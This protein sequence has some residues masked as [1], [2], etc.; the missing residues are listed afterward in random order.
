LLCLFLVEH[1]QVGRLLVRLIFILV[2]AGLFAVVLLG[3]P[4]LLLRP[5][6][7]GFD[8]VLVRII[9][10]L[11]L[12]GQE[13]FASSFT[14]LL[15]LFPLRL[16][17]AV[18]LVDSLAPHDVLLARVNGH[19]EPLEQLAH[20]TMVAVDFILSKGRDD[21][22]NVVDRLISFEIICFLAVD[23]V[24]DHA[25]GQLL[26]KKLLGLL[27]A[28]LVCLR[29]TDIITLELVKEEQ[30]L[31]D[32]SHFENTEGPDVG[33]HFLVIFTIN[34]VL[35]FDLEVSLVVVDRFENGVILSGLVQEVF[36]VELHV[37]N[38]VL[39]GLVDAI[40]LSAL[41]ADLHAHNGELAVTVRRKTGDFAL[42]PSF[43]VGKDG[44]ERETLLLICEGAVLA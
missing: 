37:L 9:E 19:L 13:L 42:F 10:L 43:L 11:L 29:L 41:L 30:T 6:F 35:T 39:H 7:V 25:L 34:K 31:N 17:L 36:R 24:V 44:L 28:H 18:V 22:L 8:V 15:L 32:L 23:L 33:Q 12:V 5:F 40:V 27:P 26:L 2:G 4:L 1:G 38:G 16:N 3:K 14:R 21:P 20:V